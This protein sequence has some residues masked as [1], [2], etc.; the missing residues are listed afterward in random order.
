MGGDF[1]SGIN[2][3][4]KMTFVDDASVISIRSVQQDENQFTA[5]GLPFVN[6]RGDVVFEVEYD[7]DTR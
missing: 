3:A 7:G 1:A 5:S 2:P 6:G 4:I